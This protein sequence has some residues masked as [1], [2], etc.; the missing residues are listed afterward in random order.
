MPK[1]ATGGWGVQRAEQSPATRAVTSSGRLRFYSRLGRHP[2]QGVSLTLWSLSEF[3]YVPSEQLLNALAARAVADID[4]FNALEVTNT[5]R[6]YARL[7]FWPDND[8][9]DALAGK[10]GFRVSMSS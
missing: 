7:G 1:A 6:A 2:L 5:A 10:V 8:L 3:E 9:L 4:S